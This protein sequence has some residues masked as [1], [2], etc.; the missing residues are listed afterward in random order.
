MSLTGAADDLVALHLIAGAD[1]AV[2][3]D[4]GG[5]IDRDNGRRKIGS[6]RIAY[7]VLSTEY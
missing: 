4:A 2:A 5:V 3:E 7:R 6:V 1:A